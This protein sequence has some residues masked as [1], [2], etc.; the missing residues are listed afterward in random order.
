MELFAGEFGNTIDVNRLG[1]MRLVDR[2]TAR[3]SVHLS[4]RRLHDPNVRIDG[5]DRLQKRSVTDRVERQIAERIAHR[6][7]VTDLPGDVEH[8]ASVSDRVS[9]DRLTDICHQNGNIETFEIATIAAMPINQRV[10]HPN[11]RSRLMQTMNE[12]AADEPAATGHYTCGPGERACCHRL[13]SH[14]R[15][16]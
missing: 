2:R 14:G 9:N 6:F 13:D 7:G 1:R 15:T 5:P 10:N 16:L 3:P 11:D 12:V 4:G 8:E